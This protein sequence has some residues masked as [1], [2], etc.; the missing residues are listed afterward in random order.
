MVA[1][2]H[3]LLHF[4]FGSRREGVFERESGRERD[5]HL[6]TLP[7]IHNLLLALIWVQ[8]PSFAGLMDEAAIF[9]Q[10]LNVQQIQQAYNAFS[11][12]MCKPTLSRLPSLPQVLR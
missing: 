8:K 2:G 11:G 10:V 7:G 9:N 5:L 4:Q 3:D 1:R 12:G 6:R